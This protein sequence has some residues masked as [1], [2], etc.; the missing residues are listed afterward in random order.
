MQRCGDPMNQWILIKRC[1]SVAS[2]THQEQKIA[3]KYSICGWDYM[4][5]Q[6]AHSGLGCWRWSH[7]EGAQGSNEGALFVLQT[8]DF[9]FFNGIKMQ[10]ASSIVNQTSLKLSMLE[11]RGPE[12][13]A[14]ATTRIVFSDSQSLTI[15]IHFANRGK[16]EASKQS[17]STASADSTLADWRNCRSWVLPG[18]KKVILLGA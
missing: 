12:S 2:W 1:R 4:V 8:F 6:I 17:P 9:R 18:W 15:Y 3:S 7:H 10:F 16:A 13:E 5:F 11:K 14:K